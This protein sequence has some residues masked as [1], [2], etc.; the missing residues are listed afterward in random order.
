ME[1]EKDFTSELAKEVAKQIPVKEVYD[2]L[3]KQS[4]DSSGQILALIPRAINAAL[5]PLHQW[6][7]QKEFNISKTKVL[8]EKKLEL[9]D[10][11]KIVQPEP[12]IAVPALQAISYCQDNEVLRNM[13]ANLLSSS[14]NIDTKFEVHPAYVEIIKQISPDEA[15]ILS[16]IYEY[17]F[18]PYINLRKDQKKQR[19]GL[20]LI[21][22][23]TRDEFNSTCEI[24]DAIPRYL[25]NLERL[26]LIDIIRDGF[27]T[28][29][30]VYDSLKNNKLVVEY[31]SITD[32]EEYK[33]TVGEK[34]FRITNFGES[35]CK[36][37][38]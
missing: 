34:Y 33:Y 20:F 17:K 37:C 26:K 14:M 19:G 27:L 31:T 9:I 24:K 30:G 5:A 6:I 16:Y 25:E 4:I 13:Y 12:Y 10:P 8:L 7:L 32:D 11:D 23:L 3:A 15:R 1:N 28:S 36:I 35:F 22:Y 2:G 29:P 18:E 38:I 21:E